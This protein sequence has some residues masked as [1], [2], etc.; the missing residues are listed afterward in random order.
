MGERSVVVV[1][2]SGRVSVYSSSAYKFILWHVPCVSCL[3]SGQEL[4]TKETS[5]LDEMGRIEC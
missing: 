5:K 4:P 3:S 2:I 1:A